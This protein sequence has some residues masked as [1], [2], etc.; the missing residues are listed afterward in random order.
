MSNEAVSL[1]SEGTSYITVL[2]NSDDDGTN[3]SYYKGCTQQYNKLQL[4]TLSCIALQISYREFFLRTKNSIS[5]IKE[6]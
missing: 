3:N 1:S 2:S 4:H 5:R 6:R